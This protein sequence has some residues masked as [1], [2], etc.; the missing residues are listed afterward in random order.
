MGRLLGQVRVVEVQ[1][2][3]QGA[4][5]EG[6][7][8][9]EGRVA[10]APQRRAVGDR[11]RLRDPAG[12]HAG[13]GCPR[14]E[15]LAT[16]T[17]NNP[18]SNLLS[19]PVLKELDQTFGQLEADDAVRVIILTA[20]GKFFSPGA[21]IKEL[22]D[23]NTMHQGSELS[24]RGQ[25]LLNRIERFD[26][27]VIAALNGACLGGGLELAMACHMR[28]AA[29]G[30]LLRLP[31][32]KLGLIPGFGGTQR[33]PRIIGPSKAAELILTGET[34]NS[35]E[36]LTWGLVNRVVPPEEVLLTAQKLAGMIM[37]K[38]RLATQ[39]ALR[40]IRTGLDSP[41][42]QGLAREA[43]LFGELC[44]TPDK[45]EGTRAFLAKRPPRFS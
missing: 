11:D 39:A 23:L 32:I 26:K 36:A 12:D 3:D 10:R 15:R 4:V 35:E 25:A 43:E 9:R 42:A 30:T 24:G 7:Q 27:P 22:A 2:A 34:I 17:L 21:D 16:V 14:A 33:L 29:A 19:T 1:I 41:L 6:G 38:G 13:L 45:K 28:V 18:P 31:E 20:S 5:G 37:A 40:A 44:E 8:V